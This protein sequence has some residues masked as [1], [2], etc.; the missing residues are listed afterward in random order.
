MSGIKYQIQKHQQA[1]NIF[2][3]INDEYKLRLKK[4]HLKADEKKR[5]EGYIAR[6]ENRIKEINSI[7]LDLKMKNNI[8]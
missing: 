3:L 6:R 5:I 4:S 2:N 1:I 7:I 8:K